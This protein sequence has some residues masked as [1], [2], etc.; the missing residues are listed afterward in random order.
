MAVEESNRLTLE[1][2]GEGGW[3]G[4]RAPR[5][6]QSDLSSPLLTWFLPLFTLLLCNTSG[7]E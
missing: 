4:P 5:R 6:L 1:T 3:V 2:P 7:P